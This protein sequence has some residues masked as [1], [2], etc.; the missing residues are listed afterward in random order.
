MSTSTGLLVLTELAGNSP[1]QLTN[2][3]AALAPFSAQISYAWILV[4][5]ATGSYL[6]WVAFFRN[7]R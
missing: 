7:E 2:L 1:I 4:W 3:Q 5:C 6:L